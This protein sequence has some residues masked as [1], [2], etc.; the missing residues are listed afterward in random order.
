[1]RGGLK[2]NTGKSLGESK[3]EPAKKVGN[4]DQKAPETGVCR[5]KLV[6]PKRKARNPELPIR[7]RGFAT[8]VARN[9]ANR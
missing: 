8:F 3:L 1:V 5:Q 2:S 7:G 4:T 9:G 6:L